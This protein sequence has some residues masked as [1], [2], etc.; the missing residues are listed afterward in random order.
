[1]LPLAPADLAQAGGIVRCG[2]C[3]RTLNALSEVYA[4]PPN[5]DSQPIASDGMPPLVAPRVE[6]NPDA[7]HE[8][9]IPSAV[10]A[11]P[12]QDTAPQGLQPDVAD[13]LDAGPI[14]DFSTPVHRQ[15]RWQRVFWPVLAVV[16]CVTLTLQ[17]TKLQ[18]GLP[19]RASHTAADREPQSLADVVQVISR[20]LHP[21]PSVED[22]IIVSAVIENRAQQSLSWPQVELSLFDASQQMIGQR[23]LLPEDYLDAPRSQ[24]L[25]F[26]A[27]SQLP[28]VVALVTEGSIATGF[29]LAFYEP[30]VAP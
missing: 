25:E 21:H 6:P 30:G 15:P 20:D 12:D 19:D 29:S 22:A 3:G 14:L 2:G 8:L 26:A 28:L 23:R 24:T 4:Y 5:G 13:R 27:N 16:L 7:Q 10:E 11:V 17:W 9:A 18:P 1:M